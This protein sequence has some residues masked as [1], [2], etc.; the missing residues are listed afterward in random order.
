MKETLTILLTIISIVCFGQTIKVTRIIDGDTFETETGDKVRLI[1]INA[2]EISDVFGEEAKRHLAELIEGKTIEIRTDNISK[3]RDRYNRLLRY[4]ILNGT[5][6]NQLMIADGFAFA[7]L[8]YHFDKAE[9]YKQS[10]LTAKQN[11]N[12]IWGNAKKETIIKEQAKNERNF[13]ESVSIKTYFI[14]G[15]VHI[16]LFVGIFYYYKK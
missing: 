16:L 11:S 2:P 10:Q 14:F 3:D 13:W 12:G 9:E 1:G 5:D 6:I 7:Y 8:K 4:V 15:L